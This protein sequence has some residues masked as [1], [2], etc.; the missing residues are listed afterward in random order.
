[1]RRK[2]KTLCSIEGCDEP[3]TT[4]S[5]CNKHYIRFRKYGDPNKSMWEVPL[6]D[7]FWP[8]VALTADDSKCWEWTH[9]LNHY[10]YGQIHYKGSPRLAHR[11]AWFLVY[12]VHPQLCLLHSCDNPRCVNPKHLRE[13][14]KRDNAVDSLERGQHAST[15][16]T[17][18]KYGHS[19]IDPTNLIKLNNKPRWRVCR[20]CANRRQRKGYAPSV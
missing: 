15:R 13:G 12:G 1:M 5:L 4:H 7:R 19:L 14:D 18:C 10:G 17:H 6:A 16:Q 20:T 8:K 9:S 2:C 11:I 3:A